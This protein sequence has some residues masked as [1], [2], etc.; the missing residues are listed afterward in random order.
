MTFNVQAGYA[1]STWNDILI[2][3]WGTTNSANPVMALY[4]TGLYVGGVKKSISVLE[5]LEE[6]DEE[7]ATLQDEVVEANINL[8]DVDLRLLELENAVYSTE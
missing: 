8:T 6:K 7:I 4:T 5:L 2:E 3:G 1:N